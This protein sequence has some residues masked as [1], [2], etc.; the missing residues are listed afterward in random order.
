M[1]KNIPQTDAA[2]APLSDLPMSGWHQASGAGLPISVAMP[3]PESFHTKASAWHLRRS[4]WRRQSGS[5][6]QRQPPSVGARAATNSFPGRLHYFHKQ[7]A[8]IS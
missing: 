5:T 2:V 3:T 6:K 7:F 1:E 4:D 8:R